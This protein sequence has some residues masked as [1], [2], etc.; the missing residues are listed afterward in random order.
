[1]INWHNT[2]ECFNA[3]SLKYMQL[4]INLLIHTTLKAIPQLA[5]FC[6]FIYSY[7]QYFCQGWIVFRVVIG[8]F[9]GRSCWG[10]VKGLVH[11]PVQDQGLLRRAEGCQ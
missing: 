5:H 9:Y 10:Q 3:V 2:K 4:Q 1:M 7:L 11:P 6:S 8:I